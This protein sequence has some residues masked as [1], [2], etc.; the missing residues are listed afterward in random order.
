MTPI[1][2]D[3]FLLK[4]INITYYQTNL[5]LLCCRQEHCQ[6]A[7]YSEQT[8]TLGVLFA[9][10]IS[11]HASARAN[12]IQNGTVDVRDTH[13]ATD[14][15][16]AWLHIH[17]SDRQWMRSSIHN[18]LAVD[19]CHTDLSSCAFCHA[20]PTIW[21]CLSTNLTDDVNCSVA[22]FKADT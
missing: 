9:P 21:N 14:C 11:H 17:S 4:K 6:T 1:L 7:A 13:D 16:S 8:G 20:A 19:R 22:I 5:L 10:T 15:I 2:V 3:M 12:W 18:F